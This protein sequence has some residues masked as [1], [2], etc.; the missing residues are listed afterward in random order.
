MHAA[1]LLQ[2]KNCYFE[3]QKLYKALQLEMIELKNQDDGAV[4]I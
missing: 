1:Q 2:E 3:L 4:K